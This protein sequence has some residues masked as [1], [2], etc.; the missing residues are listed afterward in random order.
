[1][2]FKPTYTEFPFVF[3]PTYEGALSYFIGTTCM[4]ILGLA[5]ENEYKDSGFALANSSQLPN[6]QGWASVT[7]GVDSAMNAQPIL[8]HVA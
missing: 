2:M 8:F 4:N 5:T 6:V 7:T 3:R 1:M